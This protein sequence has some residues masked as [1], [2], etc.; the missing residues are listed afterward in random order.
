MIQ[1]GSTPTAI[2][3]TS[4]N[5]AKGGPQ[6]REWGDYAP[7]V[8]AVEK[9]ALAGAARGFAPERFAALVLKIVTSRRPRTRYALPAGVAWSIFL[10]KWLPDAWWDWG[11]RRFLGW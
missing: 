10:R 9:F 3:D 8:A 11:V 2:W 1:Q 5:R 7:L 4:L 6:P